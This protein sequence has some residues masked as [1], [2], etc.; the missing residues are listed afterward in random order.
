VINRRTVLICVPLIALMFAVAVW[1]I[2]MLENWTLL[3]A[4]AVCTFVVG[5]SYL[6]GPPASADVATVQ[7]QR[8]FAAF[9]SINS[10]AVMLVGQALLILTSDNHYNENL[11]MAVYRAFGVLAGIHLLVIGNQIPKVP[12]IE[13]RS[14]ALPGGDLGPIYGPKYVQTMRTISWIIVA[15]GVAVIALALVP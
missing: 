4:P 5:I 3:A 10:C 15:F 7:R 8:R 2:I 13:S 6:C 12:S 14:F 1:Q 11:F 9:L